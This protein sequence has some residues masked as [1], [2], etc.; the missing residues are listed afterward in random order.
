MKIALGTDHAGFH[1]KERIKSWLEAEGHAVFDYGAK[2]EEP[3]DDYPDY[4]V[5]AAKAVASGEAE[6]AVI[7]GGSGQGEAIAA[8]RVNGVR[9][10]VYYGL[11]E[12]I[13]IL[14]RE[15][16]DANVLSIGARFVTSEEAQEAITI[17]LGTAFS[18]D[19]R[20]LRRIKKLDA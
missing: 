2:E 5:P 9:A 10:V 3:G 8:N 6:R 18:G 16:N 15:H 7:F 17:W 11:A 1:L 14:S 19:E 20:H 13:L 12:E 4:V